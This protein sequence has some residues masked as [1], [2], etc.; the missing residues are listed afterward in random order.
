MNVSVMLLKSA[1]TSRLW[2]ASLAHR[3]ICGGIEI[4]SLHATILPGHC[5]AGP[6]TCVAREKTFDVRYVRILSSIGAHVYVAKKFFAGGTD[7]AVAFSRAP[8]NVGESL[9]NVAKVL[10]LE[11][12]VPW[13]LGDAKQL[14]VHD[15]DVARPSGRGLYDA[16]RKNILLSDVGYPGLSGSAV[17]TANKKLVGMYTARLSSANPAAREDKVDQVL[18]LVLNHVVGPTALTHFGKDDKELIKMLHGDRN[19]KPG[20]REPHPVPQQYPAANQQVEMKSGPFEI[21]DLMEVI[22]ASHN[23]LSRRIETSHNDLS[24]R[25]D[26]RFDI[27][28]ANHNDLVR[29]RSLVL[30]L[31]DVFMSEEFE[32]WPE[33]ATKVVRGAAAVHAFDLNTDCDYGLRQE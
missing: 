19:R 7:L 11:C 33:S 32:L 28:D 9:R 8:E 22:R 4:P 23:D 27:V 2:N 1:K 29:R 3:Q 17:T 6:I 26:N 30:P 25:M 20:Q 13:K 14:I 10:K 18:R 16:T 31:H 21:K 5:V 24:R 12:V 15:L